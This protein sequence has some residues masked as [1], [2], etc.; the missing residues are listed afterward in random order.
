[1]AVSDSSVDNVEH[2]YLQNLAPGRYAIGVNGSLGTQYALSFNFV[3][4]VPAGL[5]VGILGVVGLGY[6]GWRRRGV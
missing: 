1:L 6:L 3:P 4:E 2:I 5:P